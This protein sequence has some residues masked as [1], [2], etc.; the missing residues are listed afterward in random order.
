MGLLVSIGSH[1][2]VH[3]PCVLPDVVQYH[4]VRNGKWFLVATSANEL[5]WDCEHRHEP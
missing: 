1:E 5:D 2:N 4:P 3:F